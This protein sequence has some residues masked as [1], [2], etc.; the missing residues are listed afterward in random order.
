MTKAPL[1]LTVVIPVYNE[2]RNVANALD[3]VHDYVDQVL[4]VDSGS[5]DRTVE[6][7][8]R[9][10][11]VAVTQ[12]PFVS[13][14]DKMNRALASPLIRNPWVMRLDADEVVVD[15]E[16]FFG[17]VARRLSGPDC[18]AGYYIVRRYFFLNRWVRW[19]GMYPRHFLRIWRSGAASFED[20]LLD[21]KMIVG[22]RTETLSIEIADINRAGL[23][24]WLKKHVFYAQREA[25]ESRRISRCDTVYDSELD[26][27]LHRMKVR[28]YRLPPLV[29][30]LLYFLYRITVQQGY[31]DSCAGILYHFLH[32]F[33]Y[34]EMVD[35][36]ILKNRVAR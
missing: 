25:L 33:L 29:R 18:A 17:E 24:K 32:G 21:E 14:A 16:A 6:V 19:G 26:R 7:A 11:Q 1:P 8:G 12:I 22:G 5:T 4:I 34:R 36:Y 9:Y 20:R 3:S 15:P 23:V 28:Y 27:E 31:R 2:E 13:F 35:Y 30:P 10:S